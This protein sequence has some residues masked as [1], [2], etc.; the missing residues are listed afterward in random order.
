MQYAAASRTSNTHNNQPN[1][2]RTYSPTNKLQQIAPTDTQEE[3]IT[4][5]GLR[6]INN[7]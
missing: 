7:Y 4:R 6:M 3:D 2:K 1:I 5:M